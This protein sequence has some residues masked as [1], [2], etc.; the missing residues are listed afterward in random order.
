MRKTLTW[1]E[2][3]R[4]TRQKGGTQRLAGAQEYTRD[5]ENAT[6]G[7]IHPGDHA[8]TPHSDHGPARPWLTCVAPLVVLLATGLFEPTPSATGLA[9]SLGIPYSAYP[10]VYAIRIALGVVVLSVAWSSLRPWLGTPT[11]WPPLLGLALVV[12]WVILAQ[13]QRDAG[14]TF[15][16]GERAG[17]NPF[18]TGNLGDTPALAWT[19][20]AMRA[21]G[22]VAIVPLAEELFLRGFLMRYA[23]EERFWTVPFGTLTFTSAAA[24][25][26]YAVGSHPAEAVAAVGWFAIVSG[27]A[28]ATRKPIDCILCHAATNL[29]LGAYVLATDS[30]WLL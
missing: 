10:L 9:A 20:L 30:W 26:L 6:G 12:P 11:W 14:W 28:A 18:D 4:D 8:M 15:G 29:A 1:E 24:C 17:Y 27:V 19:F 23:M 16:M 5:L 3:T 21:F 25:I 13:L 2:R 22:L 7:S